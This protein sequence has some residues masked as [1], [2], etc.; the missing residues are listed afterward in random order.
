MQM[1]TSSK[2]IELEE[3]ITLGSG[4]N[5]QK[6]ETNESGM[7]SSEQ[8]VTGIER[9]QQLAISLCEMESRMKDIETALE[10]YQSDKTNSDL[11]ND[12][13]HLDVREHLVHC[14]N[15]FQYYETSLIQ[16]TTFL[17]NQ[18]C[19]FNYLLIQLQ[20][21][22]MDL[23]N[24][25]FQSLSGKT[26]WQ[27]KLVEC[28]DKQ[29]QRN[30][31]DYLFDKNDSGSSSF[32]MATL[33]LLEKGNSQL[34]LQLS[35]NE[36]STDDAQPSLPYVQTLLGKCSLFVIII[37]WVLDHLFANQP[38]LQI[39]FL[40]QSIAPH[41]DRWIFQWIYQSIPLLT[42][43]WSKPFSIR[44]QSIN[45]EASETIIKDD[46]DHG[47]DNKNT[48]KNANANHNNYQWNLIT[49]SKEIEEYLCSRVVYCS[50]DVR[51]AVQ[52]VQS[53]MTKHT[54]EVIFFFID[55][56]PKCS[57]MMDTDNLLNIQLPQK[58]KAFV[59]GYVR[60]LISK[61]IYDY[62]DPLLLDS[63]LSSATG[64][65]APQS[66]QHHSKD[67][68]ADDIES[69]ENADMNEYNEMFAN[70]EP[71]TNSDD[72]NDVRTSEEPKLEIAYKELVDIS[73]R[74][75]RTHPCKISATMF[76]LTFLLYQLII[77]NQY[78]VHIFENVISKRADSS[79]S[80]FMCFFFLKIMEI[81]SYLRN[82]TK[83]K[84][85][86]NKRI[87]DVKKLIEMLQEELCPNVAQ[88]WI[89]CAVSYHSKN[90]SA[91]PLLG[92]L[93]CND[94]MFLSFHI[95]KICEQ[96]NCGQKLAIK[97]ID[98]DD[99]AKETKEAEKS[100]E[101]E[102]KWMMRLVTPL[103]RLG[104][105]YLLLQLFVL[106]FVA[107]KNFCCH[108]CA[109]NM[110]KDKCRCTIENSLKCIGH[111]LGRFDEIEQ[112]LSESLTS[113]A[114][115]LHVCL[116]VIPDDLLTQ[117][118]GNLFQVI[119]GC[120]V[121]GLSGRISLTSNNDISASDAA[122]IS[123]LIASVQNFELLSNQIE[124]IT[125]HTK[126]WDKFLALGDILNESQSLTGLT[127]NLRRGDY[128][129]FEKDTLKRLV[130]SLYDKSPRRDAFLAE[131]FVF[132]WKKHIFGKIVPDQLVKNL[133]SIRRKSS[134]KK[135]TEQRE[136]T[137]IE[138]NE[139]REENNE[140]E[141]DSNEHDNGETEQKYNFWKKR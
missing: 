50:K 83:K 127:T 22:D 81:F 121:Q 104:Q 94:C 54:K 25:L 116:Y 17:F 3:K 1:E 85:K 26:H 62:F 75:I 111:F 119:C 30:F 106:T 136:K 49:D 130:C 42:N 113:C 2:I 112:G 44:H 76:K 135:I 128:K 11:T 102:Q 88:L 52:Y 87:I 18:I 92:M 91:A 41:L 66:T 95:K 57:S 32:E 5:E 6:K 13:G 69:T 96:T 46:G 101:K 10:K 82:N 7:N 110:N 93:F 12:I 55:H 28:I 14:R 68:G 97:K 74:F 59:Y 126:D 100:N 114:N 38:T 37:E 86:K 137:K 70:Y 107:K 138:S 64:A 36:S 34:Q 122:R 78:F 48:T 89:A 124:Y 139:G 27:N 21:P 103:N 53:F 84:N 16:W 19:Q 23:L 35:V 79:D 15:Q 123:R 45:E 71:I 61:H 60:N 39:S 117:I 56:L 134:D 63:L 24:K 120:F 31:L 8:I 20:Y 9:C 43:I 29:L 40:Q 109:H 65:E 99:T 133:I 105:K 73:K 47:N 129:I 67:V 132:Y 4:D 115:I 72:D 141:H 90:F 108:A 98:N 118:I 131:S 77:S 125:M 51:E 33:R 58:I 80:K 140:Q